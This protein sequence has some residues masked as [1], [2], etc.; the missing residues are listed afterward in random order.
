MSSIYCHTAVL[1]YLLAAVFFFSSTGECARDDEIANERDRKERRERIILEQ[2]IIFDAAIGAAA[3]SKKFREQE[4]HNSKM[5]NA[6]LLPDHVFVSNRNFFSALK[7]ASVTGFS[8]EDEEKVLSVFYMDVTGHYITNIRALL[9]KNYIVKKRYD[10]DMLPLVYDVYRMNSRFSEKDGGNEENKVASFHSFWGLDQ[11]ILMPVIQNASNSFIKDGGGYGKNKCWLEVNTFS[12]FGFMVVDNYYLRLMFLEGT[13]LLDSL[14]KTSISSSSGASQVS[15]EVRKQVACFIKKHDAFSV[16]VKSAYEQAYEKIK[17]GCAKENRFFDYVSEGRLRGEQREFIKKILE[18]M[19]QCIQ[20][21][22]NIIDHLKRFCRFDQE[23]GSFGKGAS[24]GMADR[25]GYITSWFEHIIIGDETNPQQERQDE[26]ISDTRDECA[27][28]RSF[29]AQAPMSVNSVQTPIWAKENDK[30]LKENDKGLLEPGNVIKG[31]ENKSNASVVVDLSGS[32]SELFIKPQQQQQQQQRILLHN[33][34]QG[35]GSLKTC[36][37]ITGSVVA[38]NRRELNKNKRKTRVNSNFSKGENSQNPLPSHT[39]SLNSLCD[40][41]SRKGDQSCFNDIKNLIESSRK[42]VWLAEGTGAMR[43]FQPTFSFD[44]SAMMKEKNERKQRGKKKKH[45][46]AGLLAIMPRLYRMLSTKKFWY[47][48]IPVIATIGIATDIPELALEFLY[49]ACLASLALFYDSDEGLMSTVSSHSVIYINHGLIALAPIEIAY[50]I[51]YRKNQSKEKRKAMGNMFSAY[52]ALTAATL[53]LSIVGREHLAI[54]ENRALVPYRLP[55]YGNDSLWCDG[56]KSYT[57]CNYDRAFFVYKENYSKAQI[58]EWYRQMVSIKEEVAEIIDRDWPDE[59][60]KINI[61]AD[62][63]EM[64]SMCGLVEDNKLDRQCIMNAFLNGSVF[65]RVQKNSA[66]ISLI[67]E[68]YKKQR[69]QICFRRK[70][71]KKGDCFL[72]RLQKIKLSSGE[73]Y[74]DSMPCIITK[75]RVQKCFKEFPKKF[76][77]KDLEIKVPLEVKGERYMVCYHGKDLGWNVVLH[78]NNEL[79]EIEYGNDGESRIV[80]IKEPVA[81]E[82]LCCVIIPVHMAVKSGVAFYIYESNKLSEFLLD[83]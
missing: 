70:G 47:V 28:A 1:F 58:D 77:G 20:C 61:M 45:Q 42:M 43:G 33:K 46:A 24:G 48:A 71:I 10:D 82:E 18:N 40:G 17:Q 29:S 26:N 64:A 4:E 12:I 6:D 36:K 7:L 75:D 23:L 65:Y 9:S 78:E 16:R 8:I 38:G 19:N 5:Q 66:Y 73:V 51:F 37:A 69:E 83:Y 80:T 22:E 32:Y 60:K 52:S 74:I 14:K 49:Q 56:D 79:K 27:T 31:D 2:G 15:E 67:V 44:A 39:L 55:V 11:E 59:D 21:Q 3:Y 53:A 54:R 30:G 62:V 76:S 41:G 81:G 68:K 35:L 72:L 34:K 13:S 25:V 63:S 57:S 50:F